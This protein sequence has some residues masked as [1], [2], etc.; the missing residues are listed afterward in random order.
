MGRVRAAVTLD[1]LFLDAVRKPTH[2]TALRGS[3]GVL[4]GRL[5]HHE[6]K[7]RH[8]QWNQEVTRNHNSLQRDDIS[9]DSGLVDADIRR[10][11]GN[12]FCCNVG[13]SLPAGRSGKGGRTAEQREDEPDISVFGLGEEDF[14][15]TCCTKQRQFL[16]FNIY[17]VVC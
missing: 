1:C 13:F 17:F 5:P 9:V 6:Y 2:G 11:S 15:S 3:C 4:L 12:G 10:G 8:P 16:P 7:S 14:Q